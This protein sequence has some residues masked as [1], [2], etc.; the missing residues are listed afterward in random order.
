ME[1]A[2][3]ILLICQFR[4]F[5][6]GDAAAAGAGSL[7]ARMWFS[8]FFGMCSDFSVNLRVDFES[9]GSIGMHAR[10]N[11]LVDILS[12]TNELMEKNGLIDR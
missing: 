4:D 2:R 5:R 9:V 1:F 3:V 8:K 6:I 11:E 12:K 7:V 10:M